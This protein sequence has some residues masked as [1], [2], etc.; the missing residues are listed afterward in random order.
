[1]APDARV[2]VATLAPSRDRAMLD[3]LLRWPTLR[4]TP[5]EI[6]QLFHAAE[7]QVELLEGVEP[8]GLLIS[9]HREE[10]TVVRAAGGDPTEIV[11]SRGDPTEILEP[12]G[13]ATE[14]IEPPEA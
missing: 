12:P 6:E 5:A 14:I 11:A 8:P 10:G 2:V 13:D 1:L 3:R 9:A 4:R 7:L